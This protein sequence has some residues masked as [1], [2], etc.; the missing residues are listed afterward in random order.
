L[1]PLDVRELPRQLVLQTTNPILH[2]YKYAQAEP[3]YRLRLGLRRHEIAAV[4]EAAIDEARYRTL[5]TTDGLAV[6]TV[7]FGVRN[8][9]RQFLRIDLPEGA[10][11]WSA[12][13]DGRP[14]PPAV[15]ER[16]DQGGVLLPIPSSSDGFA[17][18]LVYASRVPALG[19]LGRLGVTLAVADVLVTS[20]RWDLFLP[21][22]LAYGA[23]SSNAKLVTDGAHVSADEMKRELEATRAGIEDPPLLEVPRAGVRYALEKLYANESGQPLR[24]SIAYASGTGATLG[25]GAALAGVLLLGFGI[26]LLRG[27]GASPRM[28]LG[29]AGLGLALAL[30][31]LSRY[32]LSPMPTVLLVAGGAALWQR[33]R[34]ARLVQASR[35]LASRPGV[36]T[37]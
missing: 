1:S 32:P 34:L 35:R 7:R 15:S 16:E 21:T 10:E 14:T 12:R 37:G 27:G 3:P 11:V 23:P 26:H 17:V 24:F 13:V 30:L 28:A 18:E 6:T 4:Q 31:V 22:E 25:Q 8:S 19:R 36:E 29:V 2:A 33:S 9:R 20:S 5:V